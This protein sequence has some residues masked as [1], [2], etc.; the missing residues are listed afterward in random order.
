[1][2]RRSLRPFPSRTC[3]CRF[4]TSRSF[5]RSSSASS[6]RRPLPYSKAGD[7]PD[8]ASEAL[9]DGAHLGT[10]QLDGQPFRASR[11]R[12]RPS[13][14]ACVRAPQHRGRATPPRPGSERRASVCPASRMPHGRSALGAA[15]RPSGHSS[16]HPSP[17]A[18][19]PPSDPPA[20]P[21]PKHP[22]RPACRLQFPRFR[23]RELQSGQS[24]SPARRCRLPC[25]EPGTVRNG[26]PTPLGQGPRS[27]SCRM[28]SWTIPQGWPVLRA[29]RTGQCFP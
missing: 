3:S 28:S 5:S 21:V 25:W 23:G 6:S 11:G 7:E 14:V 18:A 22:V 24:T 27:S 1:M 9:H 17:R 16:L 20:R 15:G 26:A 19:R 4:T 29:G 8:G 10:G 13:N 2:V 12:S